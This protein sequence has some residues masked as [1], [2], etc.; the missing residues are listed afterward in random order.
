[1]KFIT[2][3]YLYWGVSVIFLLGI[4]L[5]IYSLLGGF[6]EVQ[7]ASSPNNSYS[8][9]GKLVAGE[10]MHSVEGKTFREVREMLQEGKLKGD[11]C[12]I[13]YRDDTLAEGA[14]KRFIGV[15]LNNEVSGIPSGFQVIEIHAPKSYKAA[16]SM[17]PLV[18]PNSEKIEKA[19]RKYALAQGDSL[20]NL[21]LEI[22]YPDNS[23]LVEMFAVP[24]DSY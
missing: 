6:D 24:K 3:K 4:G 16:L 22:Y 23:V 18:M 14:I 5:S 9:A 19:L 17:H 8:I 1:M 13:D 2:K 11:L 20:Q 12:L 10:R 21:S 7:I 15:V